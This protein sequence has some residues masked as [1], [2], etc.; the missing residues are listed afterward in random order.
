MKI[1]GQGRVLGHLYRNVT[2]EGHIKRVCISH[3]R[4]CYRESAIQQLKKVVKANGGSFDE[5]I[6]KIQVN[7]ASSILAK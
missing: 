4:E 3:Y 1:H 2:T 7:I 5:V 6:G